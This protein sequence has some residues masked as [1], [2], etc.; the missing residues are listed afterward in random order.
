MDAPAAIKVTLT[1]C[2]LVAVIAA[3]AYDIYALLTSKPT[4]S[5]MI[6]DFAKR[7][8]MF[9]FAVGVLIGHLFWR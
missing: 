9:P 7:W 3:S 2:A 8:P 6:W 5:H 4:A 1:L